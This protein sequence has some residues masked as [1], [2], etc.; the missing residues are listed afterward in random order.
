MKTDVQIKDLVIEE[1]AFLPTIDEKRIL[2]TVKDGIVTLHGEVDYYFKKMAVENAVK[3]I[4]WVKGIFNEIKVVY[5]PNFKKSDSD[6]RK[7]IKNVF[8]WSQTI[9]CNKIDYDVIDGW[10]TLKGELPWEF[11]KDDATKSIENLLG[12]RGITNN[13]MI[14]PTIE[15]FQIED[16]IIRAF[17]RY[18]DLDAKHIKVLVEGHNV[19]LQGKVHS[20]L[21]KDEALMAAYYAPG[22]FKV[23]DELEIAY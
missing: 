14:K 18:A 6:I 23:E 10:V 15:P 16:K 20:M 2:P 8:E 22:V 19:K 1:L 13:I 4:K 9:P 17:N 12:V 21:E 5:A 11:M 7:A 3:R